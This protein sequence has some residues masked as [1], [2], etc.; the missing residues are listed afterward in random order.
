M[1]VHYTVLR[2]ERRL[3]PNWSDF[4]IYYLPSISKGGVTMERG[5]ECS[6]QSD[7]WIGTA[8]MSQKTAGDVRDGD[9]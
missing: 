2:S 7:G 9:S 6:G 3:D 5:A 1:G 8:V 4:S